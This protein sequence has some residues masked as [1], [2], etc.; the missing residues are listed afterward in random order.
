MGQH[1]TETDYTAI[2]VVAKLDELRNSGLDWEAFRNE[3]K[4]E[5]GKAENRYSYSKFRA[6]LP[7]LGNLE[8][9][10][11]LEG[12]SVNVLRRLGVVKGL[13]INSVPG[14]GDD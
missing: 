2:A 9:S 8:T 11:G 1:S 12:A 3:W 7:F 13:L 14:A 10:Y 5:R 4:K 6:A